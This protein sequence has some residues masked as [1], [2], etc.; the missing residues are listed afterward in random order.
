MGTLT[1]EELRDEVSKNLG[2]ALDNLTGAAQTSA[3]SRI[4]R[5]LE[6]SQV[7]VAHEYTFKELRITDSD[8]ITVTGTPSIDQYYSGMPA[9]TRKILSLI[10]QIGTDRG[11][12]LTKW[13]TRTWDQLVVT[14]AE[15]S[16]GDADIYVEDR[17][18]N[19]NLRLTW[20]PVPPQNWTLLR[21]YIIWPTPFADDGAVSVFDHKD[22][23]VIAWAT[24]W[25]FNSRGENSDAERWENTGLKLLDIAKKADM[26]E[27]DTSYVPRGGSD[28][29]EAGP[30]YW[31]DPFVKRAP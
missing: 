13:P 27:P 9:T 31:V 21:R 24:W 12:K 11:H 28:H 20:Y 25:L 1:R 8:S 3:K 22:D 2:G 17:D 26:S 30:N 10:R 29:V 14:P 16:T 23:L 5:A 18:S 15:I 4:N 19:G 7:R 6:H